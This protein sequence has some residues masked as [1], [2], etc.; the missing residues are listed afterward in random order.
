[1]ECRLRALVLSDDFVHAGHR[2]ILVRRWRRD[3][4]KRL[5]WG[6]PISGNVSGE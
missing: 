2:V 4:A 1:M 5:L 6:V 3:S